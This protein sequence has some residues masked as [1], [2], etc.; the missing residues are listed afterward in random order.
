VP[1]HGEQNED[2]RRGNRQHEHE[3]EE[4]EREL[5]APWKTRRRVDDPLA[6]AA[7][8]QDVEEPLLEVARVG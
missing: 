6:R 1:R 7:L 4:P 2:H 5:E 3:T 8:V